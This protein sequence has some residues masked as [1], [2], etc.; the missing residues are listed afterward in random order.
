MRG[1]LVGLS[2]AAAL[3]AGSL[4]FGSNRAEATI[5]AAPLGQAGQSINP[6]EKTACWRLGWRGWGLYPCGF[7]SGV[8]P[9]YS[10]YGPAYGYGSAYGYAWGPYWGA[11]WWG[12]PW[13]GWG[14]HYYRR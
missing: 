1:T 11:S 12:H 14:R 6:V 3:I 8:Y 7:Y 10:G 4:L 5:T 9:Y 13:G 2:T